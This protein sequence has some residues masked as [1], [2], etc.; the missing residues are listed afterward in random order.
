MTRN[1]GQPENK[2]NLRHDVI[3]YETVGD[4]SA[5]GTSDLSIA[6]VGRTENIF[7]KFARDRGFWYEK[8]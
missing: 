1:E 3:M 8:D 2:T 6:D 7:R 5:P 4:I